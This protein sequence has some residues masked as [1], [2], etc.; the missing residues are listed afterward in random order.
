MIGSTP[1]WYSILLTIQYTYCG[2]TSP[3]GHPKTSDGYRRSP[4]KV[5]TR[6]I[7]C[8]R[9]EMTTNPVLRPNRYTMTTEYISFYNQPEEVPSLPWTTSPFPS[10]SGQEK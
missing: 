7:N 9:K 3:K 6:Y 5:P 10:P 8:D 4:D 1:E 2:R